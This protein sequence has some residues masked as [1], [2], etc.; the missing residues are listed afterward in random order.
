M[1]KEKVK[2]RWMVEKKAINSDGELLQVVEVYAPNEKLKVA[3]RENRHLTYE[4]TP[5]HVEEPVF[6][7]FY[8]KSQHDFGEAV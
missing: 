7:S 4:V 3:R 6:P 2:T 5:I 1:Q 8:S